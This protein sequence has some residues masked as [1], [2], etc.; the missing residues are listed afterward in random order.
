MP[1]VPQRFRNICPENRGIPSGRDKQPPLGHLV[2][3]NHQ[4]VVLFATVNLHGSQ[5]HYV[6]EAQSRMR[7]LHMGEQNPPHT[8][9]AFVED[10]AGKRHRHL[11]HQGQ[12]AGLDFLGAVL[13]TFL[14]GGG[15]RY[16]LQSLQRHP[17]GLVHTMRYSLLTA[18][19]CH[20]C[21]S[22][23][24]SLQ[25][26]AVP[27]RALSPGRKDGISS[28][29]SMRLEEPASSR[30]S[31]KRQAFPKPRDCPNLASNVIAGN[32]QLAAKH[33]FPLV[34]AKNH[35]SLQLY[36]QISLIY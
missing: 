18:F 19:R 23:R 31:T 10:L 17:R 12:C 5:P 27:T 4:A 16:R 15:T 20:H 24:W 22:S 14:L 33:P 36:P 7:C 8:R 11:H 13:P 26:T 29:I 3:E 9:V 30:A 2:T 35:Y 1:L 21:I 28:T 6:I 34:G 32:H 25:V